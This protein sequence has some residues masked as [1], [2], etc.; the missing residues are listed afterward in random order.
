MATGSSGSSCTHVGGMKAVR[1]FLGDEVGGQA[2][3]D[4]SADG[5]I[6]A[7]RKLMLWETPRM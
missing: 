5:P 3:F 4:E 7:F 6:S 1:I 2:A